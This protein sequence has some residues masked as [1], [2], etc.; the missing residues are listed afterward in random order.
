MHLDKGIFTV[1]IDVEF[2]WGAADRDLS[3]DQLERIRMEVGIVRDLV[4]LFEKYSVPATW[5]IVGHLLER[6]CCWQGGIAHADSPRPVRTAAAK[7]WFWQHP[8]SGDRDNELWFDKH[9]LIEIIRKSHVPHEIA[10][11]SYAHIMYGRADTARTAVEWDLDK[12]KAIHVR[13]GLPFKSFVYPRNSIGHQELIWKAG[14]M[15]YRN[16]HRPWN[17]TSRGLVKRLSHV[18]D[19]YLPHSH[20]SLPQ[21]DAH[22]LVSMD[23]SMLLISRNGVRRLIPPAVLVRKAKK[24]I[25]QAIRRQEVFHLWFHPSNFCYQTPT[26]FSIFERILSVVATLRDRGDLDA[27]TMGEIAQRWLSR[28]DGH[29]LRSARC[30]TSPPHTS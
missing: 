30:S 4:L 21:M 18:V 17:G 20:T 23:D 29:A 14:V 27:S 5:A 22:G 8:E 16:F 25:E 3:P 7:D 11:H 19:F 6:D 24:G 1:S 12:A 28:H 10:S 15:C 13:N 2:A 9:G 26:Q